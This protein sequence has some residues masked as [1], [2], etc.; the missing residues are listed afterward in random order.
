MIMLKNL[1]LA[2]L[3][4]GSLT[5]TTFDAPKYRQNDT[6]T[7][8]I[9]TMF[10]FNV[11]TL[12]NTSSVNNYEI[13][14]YYYDEEERVSNSLGNMTISQT[15]TLQRSIYTLRYKYGID[16]QTTEQTTIY[17]YFD[18]REI[19]LDQYKTKG[20][21]LYDDK[22][23]NFDFLRV[24]TRGTDPLRA[25]N[26]VKIVQADED[27]E[28]YSMF[29]NQI[30]TEQ[31][32]DTLYNTFN[33]VDETEHL[34]DNSQANISIYDRDP[35]AIDT[36]QGNIEIELDANAT[37]INQVSNFG[38]Y[39]ILEYGEVYVNTLDEGQIL[40]PSDNS[41]FLALD[42]NEIDLHSIIPV[43]FGNTIEVIDLPSIMYDVLTMPYQFISVAFNLTLFPNTP[44]QINLAN[45]FLGIFAFLVLF[46]IIRVIVKAKA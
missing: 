39:Y 5:T 25:F 46:F 14:S 32:F 36:L 45:A 44:Y 19:Q 1:I 37:L 42:V 38:T 30:N 7:M 34:D 23:L 27:T 24:S 43:Q 40:G 3:I 13:K 22:E 28:L 11:P 9:S 4:S 21:D 15:A 17:R 12:R 41:G 35:P 16:Y 26:E 2:T 8:T 31:V 18:L 6:E 10:T 33:L 20:F 29:N